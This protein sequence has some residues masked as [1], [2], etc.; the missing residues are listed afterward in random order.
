M[1]SSRMGTNYE[2]IVVME[3]DLTFRNFQKCCLNSQQPVRS[4]R[5]Q[6]IFQGRRR[7]KK[8]YDRNT[9]DVICIFLNIR[10]AMHLAIYHYFINIGL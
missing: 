3:T 8:E 5:I 9:G 1:T 6:P 7:F 2:I 4:I 10:Q